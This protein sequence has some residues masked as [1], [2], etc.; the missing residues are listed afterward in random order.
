MPWNVGCSS[1]FELF[2]LPEDYSRLGG[3]LLVKS[4]E[5]WEGVSCDPIPAETIYE[6]PSIAI[7]QNLYAL[8][9]V[10]SILKKNRSV[11]A[12]HCLL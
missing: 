1:K 4:L 12:Y 6:N 8:H 3:E 10:S 9:H 2:P 7:A 5:L 11:W